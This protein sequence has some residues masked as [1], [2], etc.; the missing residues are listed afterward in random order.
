M[1]LY[2]RLLRYARP[3]LGRVIGAMLCLALTAGLTAMGMYL[4]KPVLD[5]VFGN[6]NQAQALFYLR[7]V[8]LAIVLTYFLKGLATYGQDYLINHIGNRIVMDVRNELYAH[9]MHQELSFFHGQRSGMLISRVTHDSTLMQAAV[10]NV[11]GRMLGAILTSASLIA[12]LFYLNWQLA[13]LSL[14]VFPLA[15]YPVLAIG[16]T[17]R[18]LSHQSQAKM[19]DVTT[20]LHES[21]TG[22]RVVKAFGMQAFEIGRFRE[23]MQRYFDVTMRALRRTALSSPLMEFIGSFGICAMIVWSGTQVING[24]S[25]TG[26]FFA[27]LGALASLY[28]QVKNLSGINNTIQQAL[29]AAQRVFELLDRP[30]LI[31]DKPNAK[32]LRGFKNKIEFRNL[33][34]GYQPDRLVLRQIQLTARAG[35][36]T[37]I[38]GRSGAGK[39]TL[40][41][42][43]PR[44][45]D[46]T[47][48]EI[49]LDGHD[50][51]DLTV[52]SLRGH[53][54][55]VTQDTILFND[56]IRN[57][58]AY[59]KPDSSQREIE[60]AA[61]A[62]NAHEFILQTAQGYETLIGERGVRLSGGQRQR[63]AIARA[64]LRNP[65]ILILDEATSA[66]DTESERLIQAALDRLM[67]SRTTLVIAHRL[68]T[69]QHAH[70]IVV[71]D[72][73]RIVERGRHAELMRRNG[74]YKKL[75]RLQFGMARGPRTEA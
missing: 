52:A 44:F 38:V 2:L 29:A 5:Q 14:L 10:S 28:P 63:L 49:V 71:L 43:L 51:R 62:A 21:I 20:V 64:V 74:I 60:A 3:Y 22:I 34:F 35:E 13:C 65:P 72:Q 42:L 18:K 8:P 58:I 61:K 53:I 47:E 55:L 31:Q 46:P 27:F 73:G 75:V 16:K 17:L 69:V 15:V 7:L 30:P 25:T 19:A 41:D 70:Q 39:T 4:I 12:L 66:L 48:G 26:T 68:S 23:E 37:A 1:Q 56:S 67:K 57:N 9:L 45:A 50:L 6:A 54:G 59:S 33:S 24:Q 11:L 32:T 36:I 40:V